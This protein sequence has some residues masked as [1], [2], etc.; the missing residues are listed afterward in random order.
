MNGVTRVNNA[1]EYLYL[2]VLWYQLLFKEVFIYNEGGTRFPGYSFFPEFREGSGVGVNLYLISY[3]LSN[4]YLIPYILSHLY[5][6]PYIFWKFIPYTLFLFIPY[7]LWYL[8]HTTYILI[9][10]NILLFETLG[11][12][13]SS[14]GPFIGKVYNEGGTRFPG[15]SFFPEFREG[16][17]VGVN[18]Y[19][20]SYI[21]SN[22]YLIPYILSHLYLIPYIF[23]KFIPYTLF[24]FIPYMLWYLYHTTY[25]LIK[26][27]I[28]LFGTLGI[29]PSSKGPFIGKVRERIP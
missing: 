24:L 1:G 13:P 26:D 22:L 16:S 12:L 14:K 23:W 29:L 25:I 20:I 4:L 18:L 6:I 10:D 11:I 28:L 15:Y 19:L 27:N 5:L 7:M 9:K 3:I 2:L 21:L 17:G 8:Y